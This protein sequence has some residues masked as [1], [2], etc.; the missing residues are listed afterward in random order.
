MPVAVEGVDLPLWG[1][2]VDVERARAEIRVLPSIYILDLLHAQCL[3][4]ATPS[5]SPTSHGWVLGPVRSSQCCEVR[6]GTP[7]PLEL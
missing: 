4:V 1:M 7:T 6:Q 2:E 5:A 3:T